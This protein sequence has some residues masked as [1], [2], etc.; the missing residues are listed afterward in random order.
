[1]G[2]NPRNATIVSPDGYFCDP[3][4]GCANRVVGV[5]L[6]EE[7]AW[8]L[9]QEFRLTSNFSGPL[10][11]SFGGNFLHYETE[12]NYYVFINALTLYTLSSFGGGV[13]DIPYVPGVT[14]NHECLASYGYGYHP[15]DPRTSHSNPSI[16]QCN[17]IDPNPISNL[18]HEGHNYFLS[19]NPY[20]LNSYA[21]F[22]EVYYN[23]VPD[24]K[25]I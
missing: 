1:L 17:Y 18:N 25:L 5:D 14:D 12:E 21:S 19:Q 10:N 7:H 13:T 11:F 20:I 4:V 15:L 3:Q 8:Q 2:T 9:S 24:L 22:G 16:S 6:S 23:I